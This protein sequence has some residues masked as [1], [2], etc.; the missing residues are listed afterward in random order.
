MNK[1]LVSITFVLED[2]HVIADVKFLQKGK[3]IL[4]LNEING[5]MNCLEVI[6]NKFEWNGTGV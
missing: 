1:K 5:I 2:D 3:K 4:H 6:R